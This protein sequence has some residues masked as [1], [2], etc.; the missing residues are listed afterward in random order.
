MIIS[1]IL[2]KGQGFPGIGSLPLFGFLWLVSELS[3]HWWVCHSDA[4]V[5]Q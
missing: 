4:N 3:Q 2:G 5:L 1:I